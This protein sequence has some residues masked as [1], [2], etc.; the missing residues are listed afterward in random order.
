MCACV[1][2]CVRACVSLPDWPFVSLSLSLWLCGYEF[3]DSPPSLAPHQLS[4]S[5]LCSVWTAFSCVC[6]C[7]YM[8]VC[9]C[10]FVLLVHVHSFFF[11]LLC[12][13]LDVYCWH[14]LRVPAIFMFL[15]KTHSKL[16]LNE[17]LNPNWAWP[18]L[19]ATCFRPMGK[20]VVTKHCVV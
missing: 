1:C 10:V 18:P 16:T 11:L 5:S 8:C 15:N 6:V 9:V 12:L 7:V 20:R 17:L 2:M 19:T 4:A 14:F 3:V 13:F